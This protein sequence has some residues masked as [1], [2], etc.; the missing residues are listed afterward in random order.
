MSRIMPNRKLMK[1]AINGTVR[2]SIP[3][4]VRA[5]AVFFD[6]VGYEIEDIFLPLGERHE[7]IVGENQGQP[8]FML[9]V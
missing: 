9:V 5:V 4:S 1:S 8:I 3:T 2:R 6:E 7:S